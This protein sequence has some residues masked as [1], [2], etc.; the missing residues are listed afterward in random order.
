MQGGTMDI[1]L[2]EPV[3][4][5]AVTTAFGVKGWVKLVSFTEPP[6]QLFEYNPVW[7][8]VQGEWRRHSIEHWRS[9][10][11]LWVARFSG[12]NDRDAALALRKAEIAIDASQLAALEDGEYY[13][14]DL[15]GC[16]VVNL[17][18]EDL[19]VVTRLMETGANDVLVLRV[20]E[21]AVTIRNARGQSLRERLI[22]YTPGYVVRQVE[23]PLKKIIV[24]WPSDF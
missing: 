7:V 9:H 8:N 19:G 1:E 2:V 17:Q 14:R 12:V 23:L 21:H 18:D 15:I 16:R 4:V 3:V 5:A 13:W 24:D 22:P 20:D 6:E 11:Q 10:G